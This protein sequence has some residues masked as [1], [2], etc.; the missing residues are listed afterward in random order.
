MDKPYS[1]ERVERLRFK[2]AIVIDLTY[3]REPEAI[4]KRL[5]KLVVLLVVE[6][7]QVLDIKAN[8]AERDGVVAKVSEL[9]IVGLDWRENVIAL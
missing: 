9:F 2:E 5:I 6:N 8:A 1:L 4:K 7:M 3:L